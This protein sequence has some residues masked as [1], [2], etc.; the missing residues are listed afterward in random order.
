MRKILA[1]LL[2]MTTL[3]PTVARAA[4]D[5]DPLPRPI[6]PTLEKFVDASPRPTVLAPMYVSLA[7]LQIYDGYSTTRG[8]QLGA[9]ESNTLIS[10][11]ADKP[12]AFWTMKAAST[13]VSIYAAECL[14]RNHRRVAAV[15]VM[16]ASNVTMGVVAAHNASVLQS[17]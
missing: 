3:A 15:A 1:G 4:D 16:V 7:G 8:V 14:W 13:A 10:A 12:A 17:R 6:R 9:K 2:L 5:P 11:F